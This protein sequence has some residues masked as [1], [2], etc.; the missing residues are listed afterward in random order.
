MAGYDLVLDCTDRPASRYLISD[1]C[2]LLQK[3]LVS[4]S[5]FQ[6]SGQL[7]LL[8]CPPGQGPCYRCVFPRPPPPESV[9]GCGEGGI[10][11][12]VVGVMGVLQALEAINI[13][14]G[15]RQAVPDSSPAML[16]LSC[17]PEGP[18]FRTVRLRG[19]RPDCFACSASGPLSL[20]S[21][22]SSMD[23]HHFCGT[24]QPV[25]L[26]DPAERVTAAEY[27]QILRL[28]PGHIL[29]DVRSKEHFSLGSIPGAINLPITELVHRGGDNLPPEVTEE[30][31]GQAA[32]Y[33]VCR[34]GND[35]Q[36]AVRR[37][38][39]LGLDRAGKRYIGDICGGIRAWRD[40]VD[41]TLPFL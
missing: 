41:P 20:E 17:P 22:Q 36:L 38:K 6:T 23:Y 13:L 1:I 32:I 10:L 18:V 14:S 9:V 12:P 40:D 21:F 8:N 3:P 5:A 11:G 33:V 37:L 34:V 31:D 28:R 4:A 35:S 7:L 19:R 24:L 25:R 26:L 39:E 29:L 2:V 15:R 27:H 30:R 16:L